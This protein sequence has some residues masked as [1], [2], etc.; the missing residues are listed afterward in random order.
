MTGIQPTL[1]NLVFYSK[2]NNIQHSQATNKGSRV[3]LPQN[4]KM[5]QNIIQDIQEMSNIM[6]NDIITRK[7]NKTLYETA[8]F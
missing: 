5:Q 6:E 2:H 3:S 7:L 4:M 1:I 8:H